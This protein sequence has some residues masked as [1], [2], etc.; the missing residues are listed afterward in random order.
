[1]NTKTGYLMFKHA[2]TYNDS[3]LMYSFLMLFQM[4]N[5][6]RHYGVALQNET[7]KHILFMAGYYSNARSCAID[8]VN[9]LQERHEVLNNRTY[10]DTLRLIR[11]YLSNHA[12][13][14]AINLLNGFALYVEGENNDYNITINNTIQY[15]NTIDEIV[16]YGCTK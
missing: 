11:I 16:D 10:T 5:S 3:E 4:I 13:D 7:G 15:L 8:D 9:D 14:K 1:M 12:I 2:K 6:C